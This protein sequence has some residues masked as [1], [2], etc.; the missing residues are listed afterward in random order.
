MNRNRSISARSQSSVSR[1]VLLSGR[2]ERIPRIS[3]HFDVYGD[4]LRRTTGGARGGSISVY[5]GGLEEELGEWGGDQLR[6][7]E[8]RKGGLA[9]WN[10]RTSFRAAGLIDRQAG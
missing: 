7:D 4:R 1:R 3:L 6:K 10:V 8:G 2:A 9:C 5:E